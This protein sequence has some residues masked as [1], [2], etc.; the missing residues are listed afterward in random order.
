MIRVCMIRVC[1]IRVCMIRVCI[2]RVCMIRVCICDTKIQQKTL[3][4]INQLLLMDKT[5]CNY[6]L[7]SG[8]D[9]FA[10]GVSNP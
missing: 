6:F 3:Y 8:S 10:A 4:T 2:I 9:F 5:Y 1:I 7:A